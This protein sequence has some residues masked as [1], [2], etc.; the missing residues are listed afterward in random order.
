MIRTKNA[1]KPLDFEN[2]SVQFGFG[3]LELIWWTTMSKLT[4][5]FI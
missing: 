4:E 5:I 1:K 3:I 2:V